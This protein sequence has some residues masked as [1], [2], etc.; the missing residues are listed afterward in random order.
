VLLVGSGKILGP[1]V[2][3]NLGDEVHDEAVTLKA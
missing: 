3:Q 2:L 1:Q